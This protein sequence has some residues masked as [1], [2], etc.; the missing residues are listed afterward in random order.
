MSMD[1]SVLHAI[2]CANGFPGA[3]MTPVTFNFT[4]AAPVVAPAPGS[5]ATPQDIHIH[6]GGTINAWVCVDST[7]DN[8]IPTTC[9]DVTCGG[10]PG[11]TCQLLNAGQEMNTG[12]APFLAQGTNLTLHVRVDRPGFV[13]SADQRLVYLFGP[14]SRTIVV[15]GNNDWSN[16]DDMMLNQADPPLGQ[17]MTYV[18]W[19]ATNSID[20]AGSV[21]FASQGPAL[22]TTCTTRYLNFYVRSSANAG[23]Q[24]YDS[25]PANPANQHPTTTNVN[26]HFWFK[27]DGSSEGVRVW[28]GAAWGVPVSPYN[29]T[30]MSGGFGTVN[31][32]VEYRVSRD[33]L[34]L[35]QANSILVLQSNFED[36]N[37]AAIFAPY[38]NGDGTPSYTFPESVGTTW[39]F[40]YANMSAANTPNAAIN[41]CIPGGRS[42]GHTACGP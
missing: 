5:Y 37:D 20:Q 21:Y 33:A 40:V 24:T 32:L 13:P 16:A 36:N 28:D 30:V 11:V 19:D 8:P 10:A 38:G 29:Y 1:G 12:S 18:A 35:T 39:H 42:V 34:G 23:T 15:D 7:N 41:N 22:C 4:A 2:T 17:Q 6:N 27:T 25:M 26:V 3:S 9:A 14:Y 31:G